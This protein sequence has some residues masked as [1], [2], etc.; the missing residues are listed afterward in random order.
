MRFEMVFK[1]ALLTGVFP[2]EWKKGNI[3]PIHKKKDKK[4]LKIIVQFFYFRF[5]VQYL[6]DLFLRKY[7]TISPLINSSLTP[8][9][10][11]NRVI[12]VSTNFNQ[13]LTKLLHLLINY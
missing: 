1:Q 7:L 4:T 2:S 9:L 11:F 3:V 13:L 5:V 10:V 12:P 6:K 8:S